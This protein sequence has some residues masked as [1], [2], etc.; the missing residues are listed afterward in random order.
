MNDARCGLRNLFLLA[1]GLDRGADEGREQ[2][3]PPARRR[4]ELRMK[5]ASD[6]PRMIGQF[7]HLGQIL[8]R[9]HPRYAHTR[10]HEMWDIAI[11]DFVAVAM[12]LDHAFLTVHLARET[13]G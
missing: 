4:G 6:E 5:L 1:R 11:V 3:M 8:G 7:D 13:A 2:R 10:I 12:A 9:R